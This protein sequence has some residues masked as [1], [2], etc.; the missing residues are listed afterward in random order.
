MNACCYGLNFFGNQKVLS[1][2]EI[3]KNDVI[4]VVGATGNVGQLGNATTAFFLLTETH[5][6][7]CSY[8]AFGS[9]GKAPDI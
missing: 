5:L 6:K 1:R 2:T 4:T 8:W 7:F 9:Y 3:K